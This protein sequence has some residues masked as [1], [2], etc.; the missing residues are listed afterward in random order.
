MIK[1]MSALAT[2]LLHTF[3]NIIVTSKVKCH[4]KAKRM[5][6]AY[7]QV[8]LQIRGLFNHGRFR[9]GFQRVVQPWEVKVRFPEGQLLR[10]VSFRTRVGRH[11]NS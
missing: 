6:P 3:V 9:S 2:S 4:S 5:A 10:R 11:R 7:S 1:K 8:L